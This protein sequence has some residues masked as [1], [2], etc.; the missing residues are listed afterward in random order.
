MNQKLAKKKQ[1]NKNKSTETQQPFDV[2]GLNATKNI[3][4]TILVAK[5]G[6]QDKTRQEKTSQVKINGSKQEGSI[7]NQKSEKSV[8]KM[9]SMD[10]IYKK[11]SDLKCCPDMEKRSYTECRK[12][13]LIQSEETS[14]SKSRIFKELPL[15]L[16]IKKINDYD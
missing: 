3:S 12:P 8:L 4:G 13:K 10:K 5:T 16:P 1:Y 7:T 2:L 11:V 15:I 14:T 9:T 6:S